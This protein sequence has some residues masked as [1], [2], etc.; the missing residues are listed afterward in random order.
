MPMEYTADHLKRE[1]VAFMASHSPFF[2]KFCHKSILYNYNIPQGKGF[3][4]KG[5]LM[6]LLEKDTWG[7]DISLHVASMMW[8]L[9]ISVLFPKSL[10]VYPIRHQHMDPSKAD[11]VVLHTG[12]VHYSGI[13]EF[14]TDLGRLRVFPVGLVAYH[15]SVARLPGRARLSH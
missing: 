3:S 12:G 9:R 13:G 2:S 4:F 1:L 14:R 10:R 7:D 6:Y 15:R 8:G 5:Y 11:L